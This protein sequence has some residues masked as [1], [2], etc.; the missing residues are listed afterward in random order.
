MRTEYLPYYVVDSSI[1][2]E[3]YRDQT[4]DQTTGSA[5]YAGMAGCRWPF[6]TEPIA[7][8]AVGRSTTYSVVARQPASCSQN[9]LLLL[10]WNQF[11]DEPATPERAMN[12]TVERSVGGLVHQPRGH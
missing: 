12:S 4:D 3:A 7:A 9:V 2:R 6:P 5:E 1:P 11:Q 10:R 8:R